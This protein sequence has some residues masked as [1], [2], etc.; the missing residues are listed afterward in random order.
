MN[1]Y[2]LI[3]CEG[4]CTKRWILSGL[5]DSRKDGKSNGGGLGVW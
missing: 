5:A 4:E 3:P 2:N 1:T